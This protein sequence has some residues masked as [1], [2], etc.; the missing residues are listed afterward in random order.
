VFD[1]RRFTLMPSG[2]HFMALEEP[3]ALAREIRTFFREFR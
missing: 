3:E 2:G 1:V